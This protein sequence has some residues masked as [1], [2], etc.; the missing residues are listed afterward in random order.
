MNPSRVGESAA[1]LARWRKCE[2]S[3]HFPLYTA[4]LESLA[5]GERLNAVQHYLR[6]LIAELATQ[7]H[8]VRLKLIEEICRAVD[9]RGRKTGTSPV[10]GL[11]HELLE[12]IA[13]P[14]L[15]DERGTKPENAYAHVWLALLPVRHPV[16]ELLNPRALLE[17]AHQLAP[18]D[19]FIVERLADERLQ[20]I[21]FSCHHLPASLL[22]SPTDIALEITELQQLASRLSEECRSLFLAA[23]SHYAEEVAK[24]VRSGGQERAI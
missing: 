14:T 5:N 1:L 11:P 16:G 22:A 21:E 9:H 8:A 6:P 13:I 20:S 7:S 12:T 18:D 24:F 3:Q 17:L 15:L 19:E 4:Y 2:I 23:A 10:P